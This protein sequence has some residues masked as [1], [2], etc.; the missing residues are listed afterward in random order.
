M[1]EEPQMNHEEKGAE[2]LI[3]YSLSH[4]DP[5]SYSDEEIIAA[6]EAVPLT[7][8][9]KEYLRKI[10][11]SPFSNSVELKSKSQAHSREMEVAGMYRLGSDQNLDE[12]VRAEIE[13]KREELLAKLKSKKQKDV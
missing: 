13:R 9:E 11:S 1:P 8:E 2:A 4:I 12:A 7:D 3:A 10:G 5:D 6:S